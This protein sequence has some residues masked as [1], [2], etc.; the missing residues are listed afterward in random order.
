MF[1]RTQA[2]SAVIRYLIIA[3]SLLSAQVACAL[4]R[5]TNNDPFPLYTSID[6]YEFLDRCRRNYLEDYCEPCYNCF[7]RLDHSVFRQSATLGGDLQEVQSSELG[8]LKGPWNVIGIFYDRN[9]R[10]AL[11]AGLGLNT[12]TS[13]SVAVCDTSFG[14]NLLTNP[15][16][17]DETKRFGFLSVPIIYDKYGARLLGQVALPCELTLEVKGGVSQIFQVPT[18]VDLTCS[19]T[20]LSCPTR[21]CTPCVGDNCTEA[22]NP[23]PCCKIISEIEPLGNSAACINADC[24]IDTPSCPCKSLVIDRIIKRKAKLEKIL[25]LNIDQNF[26]TPSP[27]NKTGFEDI[28]VNLYWSHL[29]PINKGRCDWPFFVCT[30]FASLGFTAPTAT[31]TS[32]R[33]L[34][35]LPFGNDGHWSYGGLTGMTFDFVDAFSIGGEIGFTAFASR[36]HQQYPAPT[37]E[38][39]SGIFPELVALDVHPGMNWNFAAYLGTYRFLDRFS[40]YVQYVLV[41]HDKDEFQLISRDPSAHHHEILTR[42]LHDESGFRSHLINGALNYEISPHMTLGVV[43]QI[44]IFQQNAYSSTTVLFTFETYF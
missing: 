8:N 44:P 21:D 37:N 5:L 7:F 26:L 27:F 9:K 39:Q 18:F 1:A 15:A 41:N 20:G 16:G 36:V 2:C 17:A 4:T 31:R 6:P 23:P 22:C 3:C 12:S 33:N 25:N 19:A 30:P 14:V 24:C 34:F 13:T 43:W 35:S 32:H 11:I 42:K 40:A 28:E 38:L 10:P 29:F